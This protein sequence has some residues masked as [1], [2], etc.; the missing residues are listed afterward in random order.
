VEHARTR[1]GDG[2]RDLAPWEPGMPHDLPFP[3]GIVQAD[4]RTEF[5]GS[6]RLGRHAEVRGLAALQAADGTRGEVRAELRLDF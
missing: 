6:L 1:R 2:N 3:S 4:S 5:G